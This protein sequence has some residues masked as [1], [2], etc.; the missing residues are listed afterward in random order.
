MLPSAPS[1]A[2]ARYENTLRTTWIREARN[3]QPRPAIEISSPLIASGPASIRQSLKA[4]PTTTPTPTVINAANAASRKI[5]LNRRQKSPAHQH[6]IHKS[7]ADAAAKLTSADTFRSPG[8]SSRCVEKTPLMKTPNPAQYTSVLQI[9]ACELWEGRITCAWTDD[10]C[11]PSA[12]GRSYSYTS[13][14]LPSQGSSIRRPRG[15]CAGQ[16]ACEC[17]SPR[18]TRPGSVTCTRRSLARLR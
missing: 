18:R 4:T 3:Q 12:S 5:R 13:V 1:I 6:A 11:W 16:S 15:P 14:R 9:R 7:T 17:G 8:I 2:P 10:L